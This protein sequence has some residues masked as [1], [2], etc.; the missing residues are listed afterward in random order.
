M[1]LFSVKL[2]IQMFSICNHLFIFIESKDGAYEPLGEGDVMGDTY[3]F[4][5][6]FFIIYEKVIF[7][8]SDCN[9]NYFV[10]KCVC[11]TARL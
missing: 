4:I 2:N 1:A 9:R 11:A 3:Q 10:H 6:L 8:N 7:R 5:L